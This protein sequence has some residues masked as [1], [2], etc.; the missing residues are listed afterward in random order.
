[1]ISNLL[2]CDAP[3]EP[4]IYVAAQNGGERKG[5]PDAQEVACAYS[6]SILAQNPDGRDIC[7][8]ADGR[9]VTA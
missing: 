6:F 8:G 3:D 1:M 2:L 7:R 9:Q 5:H 4:N